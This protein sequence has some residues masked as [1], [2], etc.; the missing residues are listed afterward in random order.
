MTDFI[1]RAELDVDA[2]AERVW[3][4][5]TTHAS[6]VNFGATVES[7]WV[8]GSPIVW[9]GEWEGKTFEDRGEILEADP[10]RRLVL[11]HSSPQSGAAGTAP[12]HRLVY[13]LSERDGGTHVEFTQDG[14]AS[15]SARAE[16]EKNWRQHLAAVKE[17]AES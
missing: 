15:E 14:N 13:E 5:I 4:T 16:S 12:L 3:E 1:A 2:S 6:D 11:T 7:D 10:P 9:R 17:R 8:P